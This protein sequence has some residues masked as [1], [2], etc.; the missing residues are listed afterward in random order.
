MG[1]KEKDF[2][3]LRAINIATI[4]LILMFLGLFINV[5]ISVMGVFQSEVYTTMIAA[6]SST[7][8]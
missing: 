3:M 6:V 8:P 7:Y 1:N 4:L 5:V 2:H